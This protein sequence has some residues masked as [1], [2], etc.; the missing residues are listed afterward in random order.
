MTP[1]EPVV[2]QGPETQIVEPDLATKVRYR[3]GWTVPEDYR[4]WVERDTASP[5]FWWWQLWPLLLGQAIGLW[6]VGLFVE[7]FNPW[8]YMLGAAI[9]YLAVVAFF[10]DYQRRRV[11]GWHEKRWKRKRDRDEGPDLRRFP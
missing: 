2:D 6:L 8:P 3:L 7:R 11:L 5:W 9:G 1:F 4:G 10:R